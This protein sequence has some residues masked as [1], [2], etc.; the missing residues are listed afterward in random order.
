MT[1]HV[2]VSDG[3]SNEES[4]HFE[5]LD[6]AISQAREEA[7]GLRQSGFSWVERGFYIRYGSKRYPDIL[8]IVVYDDQ[9]KLYP[10]RLE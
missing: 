7:D 10:W 3:F 9:D 2:T 4:W 5:S 8:T 6:E 1:V